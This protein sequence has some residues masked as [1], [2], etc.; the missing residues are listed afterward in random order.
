MVL[1][2]LYTVQYLWVSGQSP[3][4]HIPALFLGLGVDCSRL[5][6]CCLGIKIMLCLGNGRLSQVCESVAVSS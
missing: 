5:S 3:R 4:R 1:F 6:L 2:L